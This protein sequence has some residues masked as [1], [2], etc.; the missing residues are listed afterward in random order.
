MSKINISMNTSGGCHGKDKG[1]GK[2]CGGCGKCA[3][4]GDGHKSSANIPNNN[5]NIN[6]NDKT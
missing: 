6:S 3:N 5:T 2:K 4:K 1:E